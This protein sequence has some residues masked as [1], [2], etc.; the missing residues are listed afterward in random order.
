MPFFLLCRQ[1]TELSEHHL[2]K[3]F[4]AAMKYLTTE[5][6]QLHQSAANCMKVSKLKVLY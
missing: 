1:D 3:I 6:S 2:P 4:T 5:H